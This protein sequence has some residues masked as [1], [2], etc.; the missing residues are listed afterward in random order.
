MGKRLANGNAETKFLVEHVGQMPLY[1]DF[2]LKLNE[3]HHPFFKNYFSQ[4]KCLCIL[5]KTSGRC[6]GQVFAAGPHKL[7]CQIP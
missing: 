2:S 1:N 4:Q 6:A 3:H 7:F 5:G